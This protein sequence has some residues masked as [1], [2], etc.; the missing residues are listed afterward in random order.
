MGTIAEFHPVDSIHNPVCGDFENS[1]F[2]SPILEADGEELK[3]GRKRWAARLDSTVSIESPDL[4]L[5][6]NHSSM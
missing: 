1:N 4:E 5:L 2:D 6:R 3:S